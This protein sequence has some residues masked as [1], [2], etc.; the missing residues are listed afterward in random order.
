[1]KALLQFL[2]SRVV[3]G[4]GAVVALLRK[5]VAALRSACHSSGGKLRDIVKKALGM[6]LD[7]LSAARRTCQSAGSALLRYAQEALRG[8]PSGPEKE[9][10]REDAALVSLASCATSPA[11]S[12]CAPEPASGST[13]A[14][15]AAVESPAAAAAPIARPASGS[16]AAALVPA[17][18]HALTLL[19]G[20]RRSLRA[21][22]APGLAGL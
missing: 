2:L 14:S 3:D 19:Q 8:R 1:M 9:A 18:R 22:A 10:P 20:G 17:V 12:E 16:T 7:K 15:A 13:A 21:R 11:S 5:G 6:L 4:G